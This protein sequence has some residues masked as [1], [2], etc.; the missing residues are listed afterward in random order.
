MEAEEDRFLVASHSVTLITL[1]Y[2]LSTFHLRRPSSPLSCQLTSSVL[3]SSAKS[4]EDFLLYARSSFADFLPRVGAVRL[5]RRKTR[6]ECVFNRWHSCTR[7]FEIS[8][9][10]GRGLYTLSSISSSLSS[11]I[12]VGL[13]RR[14]LNRAFKNAVKFRLSIKRIL[15]W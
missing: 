5:A 15:S 4:V 13:D 8:P 12:E 3:P 7:L 2:S 10:K 14:W 11:K 9:S 1:G 6:S